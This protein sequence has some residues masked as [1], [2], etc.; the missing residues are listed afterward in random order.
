MYSVQRV[1]LQREVAAAHGVEEV[2][3]DRELGAEARV[4]GF[5]EQL[6]R[7][8]EDEVDRRDSTRVVAEAEQQAVLLGHAVEAPAVV[9][10][11]ARQVADFLHPLAAPRAG[12]EEGHDAER[13]ASRRREAAPEGVA[14]DQ[15]RRGRVVGVEQEVDAVEQRALQRSAARQSTK[16]PRL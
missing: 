9:R 8:V 11:L 13:P 4:H 1:D 2:E 15:L 16:N 10:R 5:A 12:I 7:V 3:A 6:A 14:R